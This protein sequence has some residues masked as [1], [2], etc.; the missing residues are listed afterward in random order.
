MKI[1][2]SGEYDQEARFRLEDIKHMPEPPEK[3]LQ[4]R[5]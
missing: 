1:K 2:M 4:V 5:F 3:N